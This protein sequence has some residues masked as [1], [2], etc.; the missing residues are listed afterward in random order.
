MRKI[1]K[2]LSA[3]LFVCASNVFAAAEEENIFAAA[4]EGSVQNFFALQGSSTYLLKELGESTF[5]FITYLS[6]IT[7]CVSRKFEVLIFIK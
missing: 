4:A 3:F 7:F 6:S 2:L 1:K 5:F